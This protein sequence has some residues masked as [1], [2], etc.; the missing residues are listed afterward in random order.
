MGLS[1]L[2][3]ISFFWQVLLAF[4]VV[5]LMPTLAI[6]SWQQ[7][8]LE[9]VLL[10]ERS[11]QLWLLA[12]EKRHAMQLM[13]QA[14]KNAV[15]QSAQTPLV[16]YFLTQANHLQ[17]RE[18][19]NPNSL[20][21]ILALGEAFL[22]MYQ[23]NAWVL[24]NQLGCVVVAVGDDLL[25]N[26]CLTTLDWQKTALGQVYRKATAQNKT[27][28]EG[29][30]WYDP[31]AQTV[32]FIASPV[33]DQQGVVQGLLIVQQN[34]NW[35]EAFVANRQGLGE[36]GEINL[37]Y[38][39]HDGKVDPLTMPRYPIN[40]QRQQA[41]FDAVRKIPLENAVLGESGMGVTIDYRGEQVLSAWL[42]EPELDI[43]LVVKQDMAELSAPIQSHRRTFIELLLGLSVMV[44]V[45]VWWFSRRL[46]LPIVRIAQQVGTLG[47]GAGYYNPLEPGLGTSKELAVLVQG[48]NQA[49]F[50]LEE[51]LDMLATQ[52]AQLEEQAADLEYNNQSLEQAISEQT[53]DL[54][55]YIAVVD[56]HV[57]TSRTDLEGH[58]LEASS[59]FCRISGYSKEA[60]IGQNHR[61]VRHPDMPADLYQDLWSTIKSGKTWRGEILNMAKD[62]K[63]YWVD[64][65]ISPT[66]DRNGKPDGYLAIRQDITERKRAEA[67]SIVD[68]MT[69]L[70]NR[71][72]FNEQLD[73]CWRMAARHHQV[74]AFIMVDVDF[75]KRYNDTQ[76]H[77]AGD[78][79]LKAV[80]SALQCAVRRSTEFAFRLG[81]EEMAIV[82][83]V[84]DPADAIHSA[85]QVQARIAAL[86]IPHPTSDAAQVITVSVGVGFFDGRRCQQATHP[87]TTQLYQLADA[88]LYQ[89]KAQGRNQ[90]VLADKV[91]VADSYLGSL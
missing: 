47:S 40:A 34:K 19:I 55:A 65:V 46:S 32:D 12:N 51:Q 7:H 1:W 10:N 24:V 17:A 82:A 80:A 20:V 81:G 43:G 64:A 91:L 54:N 58:I 11:E 29:Y 66:V 4:I 35:L 14:Q 89:A 77:Q 84:D 83:L 86:A 74:L 61:I 90:V 22:D 37:G 87:D 73:K 30:Q 3:R 59:A 21:P 38:L 23:H 9:S 5:G 41:A 26:E 63:G 25:S 18:N 49:A 85:Q 79:A 62:G 45:V 16:G 42:Y 44:L 69:G 48:T 68:D 57:I 67:L 70:Y 36:T 76:G 28:I 60:L 72:Y 52:A 6:M 75:F 78:E 53:A 33:T 2:A 88:A 13:V 31:A 71:R 15:Q 39:R 50:L 8:Q 56:E 27:V